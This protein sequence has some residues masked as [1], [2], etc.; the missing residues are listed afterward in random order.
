MAISFKLVLLLHLFGSCLLLAQ[1]KSPAKNPSDHWAFQAIRRSA[2]G[3]TGS[4]RPGANPIDLLINRHLHRE[5][6]EST[7][8]ASRRELIRRLSFDLTGLPPSP[9]EI[10]RFESDSSPEAWRRL[11]ESKLASP[12]YGERWGRHWMDVARY[13]D[14]AGDNADYPVPEARLYRDYIIDSFNSDKPY[15][16]FVQEQLAGDVLHAEGSGSERWE[17]IIATGFLA[18]SRRYGTGPFELWHLT[19]ENTLETV[20]Q[21]FM[22]LNLKCARCHD[23]KSDPLSMQDYY[24]LYGLFASTEFPWAG[25]EEIQS[26]QF[27]RLKF[28]PL[29]GDSETAGKI[30]SWTRKIA[31]LKQSLGTLETNKP[32]G[33]EDLKAW[34][35]KV[36][37]LKK[38]IRTLE[39]PGAPADLPV[40][41][42][43]RE[44]APV[45]VPLQKRGDP[46]SPG[47]AIQRCVPAAF[48]ATADFK[49][50]PGSSGRL[51]FAR[52][53]T[54]RGHPLT[55]RV[56]VNRIWQYHFGRGLV[57]TAN[58]LGTLSEPPAMRD[59]L[60]ELAVEFMDSGWSVKAM[61][62][63]IVLSEA[64][65]RTSADI[66]SS[67]GKDPSNRFHWRFERRRLDAEAIRDSILQIS[68]QLDLNRPGEHP[69][70]KPEHWTWTQHTPFKDRY[71]SRHRSVYLMTQR[72]QKHPFLALFDGPD[73]NASTESRKVST[74]PQQA[75]FT[76]N[77]SFVD[78][79][80]RRIA[81]RVLREPADFS[82]RLI[83]LQE[84]AWGR[85]P[86]ARELD[87]FRVWFEQ[88]R[89]ASGPG[90]PQGVEAWTLLAR[91][92]LSANEFIYVD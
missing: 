55:A 87:R 79:H 57:P 46:S 32:S 1:N 34:E 28:I 53:L 68:G 60:D 16:Q 4:T 14:T 82:S 11:V 12:R 13:A 3:S 30:E 38:E 62:R 29:A 80:C 72:F 36:A 83:R 33:G 35:K 49:I 17:G 81:A 88:A 76:L 67:R 74:V 66:P 73:T 22:G 15:D 59:L 75:L 90:D 58:N 84:L 48:A 85:P 70:P 50:K 2:P 45:N 9:E 44:G 61:H 42:A 71:E 18:L 56:M 63:L 47:E 77:N 24:G 43:V 40:A 69:F 86:T 7:P 25:S 52:W 64:Y 91:V 10:A 19:L 78:E 21:A 39:K 23:H 8:R 92:M 26:K 27:N 54:S 20:G 51:E 37:A 89:T 31:S 65:Q 5:A 6:L 41:Y